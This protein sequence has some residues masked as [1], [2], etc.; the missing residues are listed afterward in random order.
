MS[1]LFAFNLFGLQLDWTVS[2]AVLILILAQLAIAGVALLVLGILLLRRYLAAKRRQNILVTQASVT[3]KTERQ[4]VGIVLDT[5]AVQREF[6]MGE[7]FNSE[8]LVVTANYNTDPLSETVSGF[9]VEKPPMFEAGRATV[10]VRYGSFTS[11]YTVEVLPAEEKTPV[12]LLLDLSAVQQEFK[13]GDAFNCNGL[14]VRLDFGDGTESVVDDYTVEEPS[15]DTVGEAVVTVRRGELFATYSVT[16]AAGRSLL[17]ITLD[18]SVVRREFTAGE[19]FNH[20]GLIVTADYDAEPFNEQVEDYEVT[21]PDM[22][23][24]GAALVEVGYFGMTATYPVMIVAAGAS[25][26]DDVVL[27][28]EPLEPGVLRYN[29]SFTARLIQSSDDTKQ[30]YTVLKNELLSYR[31]VKDRMSWKRESYRY[32][33]ETVARFGFRGKALCLFL[34]L[35]PN[36]YI[37]TRYKVEDVSENKSC[38][39]TP[40]MYRIR[41]ERR[42]RRATE[43]IAVLMERI[44]AERIEREAQDYYLPYEG[45]YELVNQGLAK[46][47]LVAGDAFNGLK[48]SEEETSEEAAV[49]ATEESGAKP[50]P[51][52]VRSDEPV[53]FEEE[54]VEGGTLRYDRSFKARLIQSE[55]DTKRYYSAI[56]NE[57]LAYKKVH[58]RLSWKRETYKAGGATVARLA[59]RGST[60]CLYLPLDPAQFADTRYKVEDVSGNK[61]SEETP[62]MFRLK[63][64]KRLRLALE[65][66]A[67]VM[68]ERG[69]ER[70]DRPEED[71]YEPY[72]DIVKLIGQGL[73]RR[74]IVSKDAENLFAKK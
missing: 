21:P 35:D 15:L 10:T 16:V 56:K 65:L 49:A 8:G 63:N 53:V 51:V 11:F 23:I 70:T 31:K 4:L 19:E 32:G 18:T 41:N 5:G 66:I 3:P 67:Q 29:R 6:K 68:E 62:C 61:S 25:D 46:R 71:Y 73:V 57:L 12:G 43:L 27:E 1:N 13:A 69:I 17:G 26:E 40:C 72:Q 39:D 36:D 9:T 55:D 59:Y 7:P 48:R 64:D 74:E 28:E 38:E 30:W 50:V 42:V 58:D 44:G 14:V 45:I 54:S 37:D 33:R 52:A 47:V 24:P 22:T 34:A 60:L 2:T 20:V